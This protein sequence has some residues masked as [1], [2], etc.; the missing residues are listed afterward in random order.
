[1]KCKKVE[2]IQGDWPL[3]NEYDVDY[4]KMGPV[5]LDGT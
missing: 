5:M 3:L 4:V 2:Q 1:M